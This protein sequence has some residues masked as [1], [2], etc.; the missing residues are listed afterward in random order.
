MWDFY[1]DLGW[2]IQSEYC[3]KEECLEDWAMITIL[4]FPAGGLIG[5]YVWGRQIVK[6]L[7][8]TVNRGRLFVKG[9]NPKLQKRKKPFI[10]K[11]VIEEFAIER[12]QQMLELVRKAQDPWDPLG[13]N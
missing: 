1:R 12:S 6:G 4:V 8:N 13:E 10:K 11:L 2:A 9:V 7:W 3:R 5:A